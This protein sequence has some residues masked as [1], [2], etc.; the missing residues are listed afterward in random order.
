MITRDVFHIRL[1]DIEIQTERILDPRLNSR[2]IAII[3]SSH[4]N[5]SIIFLSSEAGQE[6]LSI[7][8]KVS[9]ARKISRGTQL[10]LYNHSLYDR[11][12]HYIYRIVSMFTPLIESQGIG[13]FFL[14][15]HGMQAIKGNM[16]N[17]GLS[18]IDRIQQ[19]TSL[20]GIV[21]ISANKLISSIITNVVPGCFHKVERGAEKQFL[22]PLHPRVLPTVQEKS[23]NHLLN[24]LMIKNVS[25][26]Q[27]MVEQID[28]FHL[29]FGRYAS[30][31]SEESKGYDTS[32]V[33]PVKI[34][35]HIIEQ[36]ILPND[37]NDSVILNAIVK[38]LAEQIALK[39]RKR[40]QLAKK[41]RLD[42]YYTDGYKGQS[43]GS[44]KKIDNR[45]VTKI[46]QSL[47][48]KANQRRNRVRS[49][50]VDVWRFY[51]HSIQY[52]LFYREESRSSDLS[53]AVEIIRNKYGNGILQTCDV[54][55]ALKHQ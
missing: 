30:N 21:G 2:P 13:Q 44:I 54:F 3:S 9:S 7:G 11:I 24:F 14:D 19:Q 46:L 26:I 51:P 27:S 6:G 53:K 20:S 42:I 4:P 23:V 48:F 40:K 17:V 32:P 52:D 15:M 5:G 29:M 28:V 18:I 43:I 47:L 36:T 34:R 33:K 38:N 39:L 10:L 41:I 31:L 50:L 12:N 45:S 22:S 16:D 55:E 37:S 25:Q 1:K 49:I 8:M 35:D